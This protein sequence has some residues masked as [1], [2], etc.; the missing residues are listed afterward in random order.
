MPQED[1]NME[2]KIRE[3]LESNGYPLEMEV[4]K[5][6]RNISDFQ[7]IQSHHYVDIET[8]KIREIDVMAELHANRWDSSIGPLVIFSALV[9]CKSRVNNPWLLFM[10]S[11]Q[12]KLYPQSLFYSSELNR[13]TIF[14]VLQRSG[15]KFFYDLPL[16]RNKEIAYS[17]VLSF[18]YNRKQKDDGNSFEAI[19]QATKSALSRSRA[20]DELYS[21]DNVVIGNS[22]VP[23]IVTESPVFECR[24]DE[25]SELEL[26][27]VDRGLCRFAGLGGDLEVCVHV[28]SKEGLGNF[29]KDLRE[30]FSLLVEFEE[31]SEKLRQNVDTL[32]S[33]YSALL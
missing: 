9:E 21:T 30:S 15:E 11:P 8:E 33:R 27:K 13:L 7:V 14:D 17:A 16:F 29:V 20:F 3:W 32:R 1:K 4:A 18:P 22:S 28:V 6:F 5:S 23:I 10:G 31:N 2:D 24:L 25:N 12:T 26:R 19:M